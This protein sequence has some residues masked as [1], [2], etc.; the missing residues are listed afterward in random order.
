MKKLAIPHILLG[1][2]SD[3]LGDFRPGIAA[4]SKLGAQSPMVDVGLTK[5]EIRRLSKNL[6]LPTWNKPQ[7]A[8]L[9]SRFPYG[10]TITQERLKRVD[11]FENSLRDLGFRQLRVRFHDTIARVEI[12]EDEL[13]RAFE[14]KNRDKIL[15]IGKNLGFTYVTLDLGG[16]RSGSLNE[17]PLITLNRNKKRIAS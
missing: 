15:S 7:M 1:T 13:D 3:D 4:A 14:K 6:G 9:S 5:G 12:A 16:F 2:N 11:E 17:T 8:C 10:T